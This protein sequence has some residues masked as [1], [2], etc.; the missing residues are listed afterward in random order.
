MLGLLLAGFALALL[1]P[2]LHRRLPGATP[3]LLALYPLCLL[4]WL[5][6]Q[7]PT[8]LGGQA[9]RSSVSWVPALDLHLSFSL[10]GLSLLLAGLICGVGALILV[11]A[12]AYLAGDPLAGRHHALL[13][14]FMASM[15]GIVLTDDAVA[16]FAFW[17]LTSLTSFLLIGHEHESKGARRA[18]LCALLVTS[19]GGLA[20]LA[21]LL[22]LAQAAG[23]PSL[24]AIAAQGEALRAHPH[25]LPA[26]ALVLLGACTK[27][28]QV[29]FHFWLPAAMVA[30]TPVSAYLHSATMVKAGVYLL[31]RL[32]PAL[33]GTTPWLLCVGGIGGLTMLVGAALALGQT[34]LKLIL[35]YS[36]ISVLGLLVLLLGLGTPLALQAAATYLL[37]H[38]LYKGALFLVAGAVD[39]E[40]GTRDLDRLGGLRRAM[41]AA[42]LAA[43]LA[44]LSM[45]G[46]P[47]LLGY[48]AKESLYEATLG[49]AGWSVTAAAALASALLCA[50]AAVFAWRPFFGPVPAPAPVPVPV[51]VQAQ[52]PHRA[53]APLVGPPLVLAAAGLLLG[54]LPGLTAP[55]V[56]AATSAML[57]RPRQVPLALW[58]GLRPPFLLG[59]LSLGTGLLIAAATVVQDE[60]G[61]RRLV[62]LFRFSWARVDR[63]GPARLYEHALSGLFALARWQTAILQSGQLRRYLLIVIATAV[64]LVGFTLLYLD[65]EDLRRAPGIG[66]PGARG[67]LL[68][69]L[70]A[71]AAFGAARAQ[72]RMAGVA[73]LSLAGTGVVLI[74][75]VSGA[76]D[77]AM[78]QAL[79]ETLTVIFLVQ[80]VYRL[81]RLSGPP[82]PAADV[83][84]AAL[85]GGLMTALLLAVEA[86]RAPRTISDYFVAQSQTA[87]HGRN[88]VNTILVDFRALDTLGEITVLTLAG[89]GVYALLWLRP[90]AEGPR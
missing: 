17:E 35:A 10:D 9:V 62:R 50:V 65:R 28:A 26:L 37:A 40:T 36:T 53:P 15:L 78:T 51:H 55:L 70:V 34:D 31:A 14:C 5:A 63:W 57:L 21:G 23:S 27:S 52:A 86:A 47:P 16:L 20:L 24:S 68:T 30:P 83:V 90:S 81:P 22:L 84:F 60:R 75:T 6:V 71:A 72:S 89:A 38:A 66:W 42:A 79:V 77:V 43:A 58:H 59:L 4:L 69:G 45:A 3:W 19:G 32:H 48:L 29:P 88:V 76:A 80:V 74:F 85:G 7:A 44:A 33:S 73:A 82:A 64:G 49:A 12:G 87:A 56:S 67:L 11:Y 25:Y 2:S 41:P 8:V 54:A 61:R 39:H 1:T 18:A 46:V 13:L